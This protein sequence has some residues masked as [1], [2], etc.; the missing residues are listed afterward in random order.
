MSSCRATNRFARRF[1]DLR[2]E[3]ERSRYRVH[4]VT[5]TQS[6]GAL[7]YDRGPMPFE[8]WPA[9]EGRS[10]VELETTSTDSSPGA[11]LADHCR[12]PVGPWLFRVTEPGVAVHVR[13]RTVRPSVDYLLV[14]RDGTQVPGMENSEVRFATQ[15]AAATSFRVPSV[16]DQ[17]L[18]EGLLSV[19]LS[20][21]PEVSIGPAGLVPAAWD[22]EGLAE[23]PA[24]ESPLL[25]IRST[26]AVSRCIVSTETDAREAPWPEG[27]DT[28]IL[29]VDDLAPGTH[30]LDVVLLDEQGVPISQGRLV[31]VLRE[32]VDSASSASA[33]QGIAGQVLSAAPHPQ[34]PL[35][36]VESL[37][38]VGT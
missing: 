33:R 6:R 5:G 26:H 28:L 4:G 19:G 11:L 7:L 13:T 31:V 14:T 37:G 16:V 24:G 9:V 30:A 36:R 21:A 34:G 12:M 20:V 3:L 10:L 32:P 22:G 15:D 18:T 25:A 8:Q 17:E 29:R 38:G 1:P 2:A 27:T 35:V 23:W